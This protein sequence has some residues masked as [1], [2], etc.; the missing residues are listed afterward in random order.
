M[1]GKLLCKSRF[2]LSSWRRKQDMV[3]VSNAQ[4]CYAAAKTA[5]GNRTLN[6]QSNAVTVV[7]APH[8][9]ISIYSIVYMYN[10]VDERSENLENLRCHSVIAD[11]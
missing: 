6:L 3:T 5:A 1:A 10:E 11:V 7:A 2:Q 8:N 4:D 9:L